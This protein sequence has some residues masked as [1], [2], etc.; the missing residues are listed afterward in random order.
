MWRTYMRHASNGWQMP[1]QM[2][3]HGSGVAKSRPCVVRRRV[4]SASRPGVGREDPISGHRRLAFVGFLRPSRRSM[5]KPM[6]TS[7]LGVMPRE[8]PPQR[9]DYMRARAVSESL[10]TTCEGCGTSLRNRRAMRRPLAPLW[11]RARS[12]L[13]ERMRSIHLRRG[14]HRASAEDADAKAGPTNAYANTAELPVAGGGMTGT[15][16][17][18]P[19]VRYRESHGVSRRVAVAV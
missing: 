5:D 13:R 2:S 7:K 14:S 4:I 16:F 11:P 1:Q 18:S 3:C 8:L 9:A 12:S 17:S 19:R 6:A 10:A 15:G